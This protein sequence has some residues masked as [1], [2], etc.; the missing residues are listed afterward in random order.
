M[1][2]DETEKHAQVQVEPA[3]GF[4]KQTIVGSEGG[5]P[6]EPGVDPNE[7]CERW[8]CAEVRRDERRFRKFVLFTFLE[9]F[10]KELGE[11]ECRFD[12]YNGDFVL[13]GFPFTLERL[14]VDYARMHDPVP[15]SKFDIEEVRAFCRMNGLTAEETAT[16]IRNH[17]VRGGA[18]GM[19]I[20]LQSAVDGILASRLAEGAR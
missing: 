20:D 5:I 12:V 15:I 2:R 10:K 19:A 14:H 9:F 1:E 6:D 13:H 17:Y 16:L 7:R 4:E 18:I 3:D 11:C 8:K